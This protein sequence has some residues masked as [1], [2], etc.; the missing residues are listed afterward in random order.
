MEL[1]Q[2]IN[3]KRIIVRRCNPYPARRVAVISH[4]RFVPSYFIF[5]SMTMMTHIPPNVTANWYVRHGE[6]IS[7]RQV[8]GLYEQLQ[9]ND[10]PSPIKD[11]S[12]RSVVKNYMLR[13]DMAVGRACT[14]APVATVM[15]S[16]RSILSLLSIFLMPSEQVN[17]LI[18]KSIFSPAELCDSHRRGSD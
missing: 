17:C 1:T 14:P 10:S 2:F 6:T 12:G 15:L 7:N 11:Y 3:G 4:G 9:R 18:A 5:G 16:F 13:A 8:M